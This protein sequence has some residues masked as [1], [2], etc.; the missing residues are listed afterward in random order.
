MQP[1]WHPCVAL[2]PRAISVSAWVSPLILA[3]PAK[4][5]GREIVGGIAAGLVD[6]VG[7]HVGA[8]GRQAPRPVTGM[9]VG[10]R[11]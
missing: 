3:A 10:D 6:H 8:V 7:Q 11:P 4:L 2:P 5:T 9:L 1:R